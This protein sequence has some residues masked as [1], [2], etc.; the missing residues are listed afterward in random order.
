M[1]SWRQ[2]HPNYRVV[3]ETTGPDL[4]S[5]TEVF[6]FTDEQGLVVS[7]MQ[8]QMRQPISL[9]FVLETEGERVRAYFPSLDQIATIDPQQETARFLTQIGWTGESLDGTLPIRLA[10]ASFVELGAD[11]RALT[12]VF[13][14]ARFNMPRAAGDLFLTIQL[15]EDGRARSLEQLT[16]GLRVVSKLTYLDE[17]RTRIQE[18]APKIPATAVT[19]RK[20]FKEILQE[21]ANLKQST[22]AKPI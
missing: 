15:D 21:Q 4:A 17:D 18:A 2:M 3:V 10:R 22:P 1:Q 14:G 5:T 12:M 8:T 9:T 6:R 19:T 11:Y 13:P 16:L 7:R 20:S